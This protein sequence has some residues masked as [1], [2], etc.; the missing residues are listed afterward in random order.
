VARAQTRPSARERGWFDDALVLWF[1]PSGR[2]DCV[3]RCRCRDSC[4]LRTLRD[5]NYL[6]NKVC[7]TSQGHFEIQVLQ[8]YIQPLLLLTY[9]IPSR[10]CVFV[11]P[12]VVN[13]TV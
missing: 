3:L 11:W 2:A 6:E 10:D 4:L 1:G 7:N 8:E 9:P 5:S 12:L 13:L